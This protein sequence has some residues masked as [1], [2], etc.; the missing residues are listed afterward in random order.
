MQFSPRGMATAIGSFPHQ[1]P[2]SACELILKSIP[3]IPIWPQLPNSSFRE[4]MEIQYSEGMPCVVVDEAHEKIYF[5]TGGDSTSDLESFYENVLAE[6][7]D[8]FRISP[9]YSRGLYRMEK[10]LTGGDLSEVKFFKHHVIG[11]LTFGLSKTDQGKRS[12]YYNEIFRDVV[13]KGIAMKARWMLNRFKFLGRPQICFVDEPIFAA[14]GSSTY[15][16]VQRSDA[17]NCLGE[18]IESIHREGAL[19][20]THCCGNTE[21]TILIDAGVDIISFDAY[22]Y[23]ETIGYYADRIGEFLE[24]GGILA[25][26]IVP[27]S[28]KIRE[29]TPQSLVKRLEELVNAL[30]SKGID[31]NLIFEQCL[32]TP[33]CGT[34]SLSVDLAEE[35]FGKLAELSRL[36]RH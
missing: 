1:E 25:W 10:I 34:G 9:E 13:T 6:N 28:E 26:G 18:V 20:G 2:E 15:V 16:S 36:L 11:P 29:Q 14:F 7:L 4:Q 3:E 31:K 27:T 12:I 33:S 17:V 5:D 22:G 30:A 24:K 32:A 19:A 21:W 8:Y 35:I 23:G